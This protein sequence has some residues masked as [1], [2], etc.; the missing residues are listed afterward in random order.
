MK[1]IYSIIVLPT[2]VHTSV[3]FTYTD[4]LSSSE[5]FDKFNDTYTSWLDMLLEVM[6][7]EYV[8]HQP[9]LELHILLV[10]LMGDIR[11]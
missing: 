5:S 2:T 6:K 10:R 11:R 4:F 9:C 1:R 7:L 8:P 3:V